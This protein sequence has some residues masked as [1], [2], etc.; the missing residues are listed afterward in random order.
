VHTTKSRSALLQISF[1]SGSDY[2]KSRKSA[3]VSVETD[4]YLVYMNPDANAE[5]PARKEAQEFNPALVDEEGIHPERTK[6]AEL[7]VLEQEQPDKEVEEKPGQS[8]GWHQFK[9][10]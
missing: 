3:G 7:I 10:P 8:G 2:G 9:T 5:D 6:E 4:G 1:R